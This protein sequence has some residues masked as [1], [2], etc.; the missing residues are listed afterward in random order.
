MS[1]IGRYILPS[2]SIWLFQRFLS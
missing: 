2:S 1:P